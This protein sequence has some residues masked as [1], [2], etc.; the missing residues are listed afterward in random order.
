MLRF[1]FLACFGLTLGSYA[2]AQDTGT[3][4][5]APPCSQEAYKQFDFW[6]G[7][8][9]VT[10]PDG[11]VAGI[12]E[13][14]REEGG[15]LI[16]ETWTSAT[17][18]SGQSY[19]YYNPASD[20]WRQVWVSSGFIIDYEGGLTETGSMKL[21]GTITYTASALEADFTGEWSLNE[22]GTVTQHFEQ[23][24]PEKE[25][26]SAWFTGTYTKIEPAQP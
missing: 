11:A 21:A 10:T 18:G 13:I 7:T 9:E 12:N 14:T 15:C 25:E 20:K 17:G 6:L 24:D 16:L 3:A 23:Y 4:S 1:A 22:D 26:W 8:W 5:P 2:S 19:N